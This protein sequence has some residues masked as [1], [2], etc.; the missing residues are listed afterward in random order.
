M[1]CTE[2]NH[3]ALEAIPVD[4]LSV[5]LNQSPVFGEEFWTGTDRKR[6]GVED[7]AE[8]A[9]AHYAPKLG[10]LTVELVK[11]LDRLPRSL[12]LAPNPLSL[13]SPLSVF[14]LVGLPQFRKV[15]LDP[16]DLKMAARNLVHD[17]LEGDL[18]RFRTEQNDLAMRLASF[19]LRVELIT[20]DVE[21]EC[22]MAAR[23]DEDAVAFSAFADVETSSALNLELRSGARSDMKTDC[24]SK[25]DAYAGGGI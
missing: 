4:L 22:N 17:G 7:V 9:L 20:I 10:N 12:Q 2:I 3:I 18:I 24:W 11:G 23:K 6:R 8:H 21:R 5:E 13:L 25:W 14:V 19:P 15:F 16:L 1:K